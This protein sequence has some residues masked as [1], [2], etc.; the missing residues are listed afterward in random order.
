MQLSDCVSQ[1]TFRYYRRASL[2]LVF[3]A[4]YFSYGGSIR[5][6][7]RRFIALACLSSTNLLLVVSSTIRL[8]DHFEGRT[9]RLPNLFLLNRSLDWELSGA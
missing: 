7:G 8:P 3:M 4:P 5:T 1:G 9:P 6:T 2:S